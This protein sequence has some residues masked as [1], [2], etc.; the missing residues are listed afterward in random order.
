MA[1]TVPETF[2][3]AH[4][5][6]RSAPTIELLNQCKVSFDAGDNQVLIEVPGRLWPSMGEIVQN[7][8]PV[9]LEVDGVSFSCPDLG[10]SRYLVRANLWPVGVQDKAERTS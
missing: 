7:I 1:N 2:S 5:L 10:I 9:R 6:T 4:L 3:I 8:N